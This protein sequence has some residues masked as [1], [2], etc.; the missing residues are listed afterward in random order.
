MPVGKPLQLRLFVEGEEIPVISAQVSISIGAPAAASI[1]IIPL[2][3]ALSFHPRTMVHLFFLDDFQVRVD[4]NNAQNRKEEDRLNI[5]FLDNYKLLFSGEFIGFQFVKTPSSRAVIMQCLDFSSYWDAVHATALEYGPNGN[6]LTHQGAL[7]ASNTGLFDDIVNTTSDQLV[8]WIAQKPL[9]EGLTSVSGLAGGVIRM[10]EMMG[11]VVNHHRGVNDFFSIAQLRCRV[12]EQI[13]AE[14]N[15]NTA[16]GLLKVS[17]FD[18]WIRNGLQNIGQ[19]ISFRDMLKLLFGYVHYEVVP[20]PAAKFDPVLKGSTSTQTTS[21]PLF[22]H[23]Q[24]KRAITDLES[25]KPALGKY[26]SSKDVVELQVASSTYKQQLKDI[27]TG[28]ALLQSAKRSVSKSVK[29]V[30]AELAK[31]INI[32]EANPRP[33]DSDFIQKVID[34]I[35]ATVK[36]IKDSAERVVTSSKATTTATTQRLRAQIIRPDCFFS[37]PP[38]CNVIF[39]EQYTQLA[40]D[41]MHLAEVT[42]SLVLAYNTLV[43][44]DALLA[45]R[46]LAPSV[47]VDTELLAVKPGK[48]GYRALMKHELH[49][50][51]IPRSE[52]LPNTASFSGAKTDTAKDSVKNERS[53]WA[54]KIALFHF[55]KYRFGPRTASVGGRFNPYLVCGFPALIITRPFIIPGI[56]QS[57]TSSDSDTIESVLGNSQTTTN[58]KTFLGELAAAPS[59]L[60][61]MIGGLSHSVDQNGGSTS[62]SLSHVRQHLG[63]DDE[64]LGVLLKAKG[65][66]KKRIRVRLT[67]DDVARSQKQSLRDILL[68]V[69]PQVS[70][71]P[72]STGSKRGLKEKTAASPKKT[73]DLAA[74]KKIDEEFQA[75]FQVTDEN[76]LTSVPAAPPPLTIKGQIDKISRD[77][78]VPN[79][80]GK[81]TKNGKG[82]FGRIIGVEVIDASLV[83]LSSVVT[84]TPAAADAAA[85]GPVAPAD[86]TQQVPATRTKKATKRQKEIKGQVYTEV[87][88]YEEI[89]V[90]ISVPTPVEEV[91]RPKWFSD[92]Y[93]NTN[94]GKK[95]YQPFFGVPSIIDEA[96]FEGLASTTTGSEPPNNVDGDSKDAETDLSVIVDAISADE[97]AAA[98]RSIERSV[99]FISYIYGLVK[100]K[101]L[102]VDD[103]IRQYANRPIAT[104]PQMLGDPDLDLEVDSKGVASVKTV[105]LPDGTSRT[106]RIGFHSLAVH[107]KVVDQGN[108]AGLLV[109]PD[110]QVQRINNTGKSEPI[111]PEYD[112]RKEKKDRVRLYIAALGRGPGFRG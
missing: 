84:F 71:T 4:A 85:T 98:K 27:D 30:R 25:V 108:L 20:N 24:A 8:R 26:I 61:G 89:D 9:T 50:G 95:I 94:I 15:D 62:V 48:E 96:N 58:G 16:A 79:P 12:M 109:E 111:P 18:E 28:L 56:S 29:K 31:G 81:L 44:K 106:P 35:D 14:E 43:G 13:T 83:Q 60:I 72:S 82:V 21:A 76:N 65:N 3:E 103:F 57:S 34:A 45:D 41:R 102:D 86:P 69:T 2:D 93:S 92:S 22:Q 97:D 112:I 88:L 90:P 110:L 73:W 10:L 1:Q 53:S 33:K 101:G 75:T 105:T 80:A 67:A 59:Q 107:P 6:A 100:V 77:L 64:F 70:P 91:I 11:G 87:I 36:A 52:W 104:L 66:V 7:R 49:T 38:R 68:K 42:R 5:P 19:Q 46:I 51:I 23:P 37:P 54:R 40:Y 78:L 74:K 55:F 63:I 32:L 17:V 99:N 39:P 47:G